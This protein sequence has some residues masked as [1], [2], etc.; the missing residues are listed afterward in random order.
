MPRADVW[1]A[2]VQLP[3]T[4]LSLAWSGHDVLSL[5]INIEVSDIYCHI[6]SVIT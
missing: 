2:Q 1:V 6:A 3:H 4:C 5:F